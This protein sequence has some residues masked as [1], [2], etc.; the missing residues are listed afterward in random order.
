MI[1]KC[2]SNPKHSVILKILT[3]KPLPFIS[4]ELLE[5]LLSE[6]VLEH[7]TVLRKLS[8]LPTGAIL[9][10]HQPVI[11]VVSKFPF[12]NTALEGESIQS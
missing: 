12:Y 10:Q 8:D 3:T 4:S 2:P 7:C 11:K 5:L 1:F 9:Q 6:Y